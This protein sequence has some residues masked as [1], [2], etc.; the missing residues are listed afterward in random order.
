MTAPADD[1]TET[2]VRFTEAAAA[3]VP[4]AEVEPELMSS[5]QRFFNRELSWLSFN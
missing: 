5:P 1:L 3:A 4:H 2:A